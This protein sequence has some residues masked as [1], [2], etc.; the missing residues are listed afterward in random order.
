MA[1][2]VF[3]VDAS[4]W[5][6]AIGRHPR[7]RADADGA[8][9]NFGLGGKCALVT[10]GSMGIGNAVAR[11][12]AEQGARVV[13]AARHVAPLDEAAN[14]INRATRSEAVKGI[15]ADCSDSQE[16]E[17]LVSASYQH[18]GGIDILVNAIGMAKGGDF[19]K[20]TDAEWEDSLALKLMGQIRCCRAVV[21]HMLRRGWGRIVNISG[22]QWKRPL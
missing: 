18:L 9:M 12:L 21:P 1:C 15:A 2:G 6:Q 8:A 20:L 5:T 16:I 14:A 19:L 13:I 17:R 10:G 4:R 7:Q 11:V 22:T 3:Q